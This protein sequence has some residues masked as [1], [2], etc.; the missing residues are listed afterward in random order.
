M[1]ASQI[2]H[3]DS[4]VF[5]VFVLSIEA[6]GKQHLR[7]KLKD[8][9]GPTGPTG[10]Q[11]P[12]GSTGL[13]GPTGPQG[14]QGDPGTPADQSLLV[15]PTGGA[16]SAAGGAGAGAIFGGGGAAWE[17][18]P[19]RRA[20]SAAATCLQFAPTGQVQVPPIVGRP[21]RAWS[22]VMRCR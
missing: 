17:P 4:T 9:I 1:L 2:P 7:K 3:T 10:P 20:K 18:L 12:Q 16:Q 15:R 5:D 13:T 21:L 11:G 14:P 19:R 22:M 8:E 6:D